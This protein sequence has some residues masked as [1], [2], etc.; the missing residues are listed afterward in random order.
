MLYLIDT[1][2]INLKQTLTMSKRDE[3][4][5][6]YAKDIK[7]KFGEE[8]DMDLLTKVTVGCGPAIYGKDAETVSA[9]SESEIATVKNKFLIKKL[10]L[11]DSPELDSAIKKVMDK[12]GSSNKSKFRAVVYYELTKHFN[13]EAI[14]N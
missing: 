5:E 12:Y 6:K 11:S 7:A 8:P 13:K 10:G 3:L 4:I 2:L 1:I 9:G 14:Y